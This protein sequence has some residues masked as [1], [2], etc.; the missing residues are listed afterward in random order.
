MDP[1]RAFVF[2]AV[3]LTAGLTLWGI[4]WPPAFSGFVLLAPIIFVGVADMRQTTHAIRRNFPVIGHGRYLLEAIRPEINQYFVESNTDGTPFSRELRSLVY[5]RA[6]NVTDTVPFGTERDVYAVGYEWINHS[7]LARTPTDHSPRISIGGRYCERPYSAS[8]LNISAMSFGALSHAAVRA[9]NRGAK[10][11]NFAH[12]TGEG[13]LSPYHAEGGGDLIWQLGTGYFGARDAEG[14]FDPEAFSDKARLENV[15]MIELKISQGAK[16]GHGG[17]LPAGKLTAEI[18][19]IRG[20]PLGKD[21]LSPPG[22]RAFSTPRELL[23]FIEE[24]RRLSGRKPVGF[25]LCVGKP[26]ELFAIAKAMLETGI[27]PDFI[28]VDGAEGGTGAAPLEFSNVV[29]TPLREGLVL[30]HN[31]LTGIGMRDQ[32]R[33]LAA[34]RVITG[35]DVAHRLALGADAVYSARGMM[36]ALGCIQARRCNSNDCPTGIATQ[37]PALIKGLSVTD[38]AS[39]VANFHRNTL[40]AFAEILAAAGLEHPEDLRPWH[41][42]RRLNAT[43]VRSLADVYH[44]VEPGAFLE[45]DIPEQFRSA[46]HAARPDSFERVE[47]ARPTPYV[48]LAVVN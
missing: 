3:T 2:L 11:G 25:K 29:G 4:A 7:M 16:P 27:T 31:T 26:S 35:F 1:R 15:K 5:Q 33:I 10:L 8:L 6:K 46:W 20:V 37:N 19:Q 12:N 45:N 32:V 21:V 42:Q 22:H 43:D 14:N 38:K 30:V 40:H 41:V 23:L 39:R 34:G 24:L 13:G 28:T 44:F 47:P 36:F 9:L 48:R 18:A 17:I